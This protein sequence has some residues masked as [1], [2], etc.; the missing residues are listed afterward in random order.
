VYNILLKYLDLSTRQSP[1]RPS[2][3]SA[4]SDDEYS[5]DGDYDEGH[6]YYD[7]HIPFYLFHPWPRAYN[8][9][10]SLRTNDEWRV[11]YHSR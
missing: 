1:A 11:Y 4:Y 8:I 6:G 3:Y 5:D 10:V 2:G 9:Q 7:T